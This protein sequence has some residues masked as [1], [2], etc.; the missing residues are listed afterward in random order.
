[1][2]EKNITILHANDIHGQLNFS[3]GKDLEIKGGISLLSGYLKKARHEGPVFF[4]I[5]GDVLQED[6]LGSDYKGTN[7]VE[8]INYLDPDCLSL[9]NHELDYGL[10]HLL[11]F[12]GCIKSPIICANLMVSNLEQMVFMPSMIHEVGGVKMLLIGVIPQ[13]FFNK[14]MSDDFNRSML[15]YKDTYDAIRDE[16][17]AH[18]EDKPDL[19]VIMSHYGIEGDRNL[20]QN[21]P[22]DI[23]VDLIL[24]GHTHIDMDEAEVINGIPIA[25]SSYGTTHIG[26][27]DLTVDTGKGGIKDFTWRRIPLTAETSDFDYMVDDLADRV[28]FNKK[29]KRDNTVICEFEKVFEHKSRLYETDLGNFVADVFAEE[30]GVDLVILQSGSIRRPEC[31][32]V[33]TQK[34]LSEAYP[35]DDRFIEVSLSGKELKDAFDYLFSLKPDGSVMNGTFLYSNG[36]R[37]VADGAKCW[38]EGCRVES[39]TLNGMELSDDKMYR[40]GMTRNCVSNT[41]RYFDLKIDENRQKVLSLSTFSD[42]ARWCLRQEEKIPVPPKGRFELKNFEG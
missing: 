6:V 1:M 37:L 31:G 5:C 36:F 11:I 8:L 29:V 39:I 28:T 33:V 23:H 14:I 30:Y 15:Y 42:L 26:R 32:P 21:M 13:A 25:Q 18:K 12:K 22:E 35:F 7:T 38:Q 16:I 10:S 2:N 27:F 41:P 24:G 4:G 19:V 3:V 9:G 17:E 34:D 20:A 40:V